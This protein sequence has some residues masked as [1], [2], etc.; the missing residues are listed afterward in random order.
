MVVDPDGLR[1]LRSARCWER[2]ASGSGLGWLADALWRGDRAV[3]GG[4]RCGSRS[5]GASTSPSCSVSA[6]GT[7][8]VFDEYARWVA[9]G[10]A[11][12]ISLP[13]PDVV[14]LGGESLP[15]ATS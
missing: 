2:Y 3:V 14:A 10:V 4:G 1:V 13:D 6:T 9:L 11:N 12:L 8:R 7:V 15:W 5:Y